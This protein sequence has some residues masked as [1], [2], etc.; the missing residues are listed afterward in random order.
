[1][2]GGGGGGGHA[3]PGVV[4]P[5]TGSEAEGSSPQPGCAA[6]PAGHHR[7]RRGAAGSRPSSS[8]LP[9]GLAYGALLGES[10]CRDTGTGRKQPNCS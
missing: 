8:C 6:G 7:G 9:W 5:P 10:P 4:R 2:G 3:A 1:M